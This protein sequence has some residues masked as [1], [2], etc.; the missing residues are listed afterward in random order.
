MSRDADSRTLADH[1]FRY[2]EELRPTISRS[3]MSSSSWNGGRSSSRRASSQTVRPSVARHQT[4]PQATDNNRRPG[5]GS[6]P[7]AQG[8]ALP[9]LGWWR[10]TP[11]TVRTSCAQCGQLRAYTYRVRYFG[12]FARPDLPMAWPRRT[13]E[14]R[15]RHAT[16]SP[17]RSRRGG[18][19]GNASTSRIVVSRSSIAA[20]NSSRER[21]SMASTP[22]W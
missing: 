20:G 19:C 15:S 4:R 5:V 12:Q 8:N 21:R 18:P 22:G 10:S 13:P 6:R 7:R 11:A 1:L 3:K 17:N 2:I 16:F 9:P 14:I